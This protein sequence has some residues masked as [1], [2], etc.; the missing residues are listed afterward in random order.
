MPDRRPAPVP[1]LML[2]TD[3]QD[4]RGRDLVQI[5]VAAVRGGVDMVQVREKDLE[6]AELLELA[7]R[8]VRALPTSA[9]VAING[10]ALVAAALEANLHLPADVPLPASRVWPLWGRSAHSMK[11]AVKAAAEQPDYLLLGTIFPTGSKPG[12]PGSGLTLVQA[13]VQAV[14]P[15]PVLAIGGID[16]TNAAAVIRAG[17]HGIAVRSAILTADDPE[18]AA[19]RLRRIVDQALVP[20]HP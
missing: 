14:S 10:N 6:T 19:R 11:E 7:S 4:T 12:H 20:T 13:V 15:L 1:R 18:D 17:A 16:E 5:A 9:L 3:R 8:I 2:V